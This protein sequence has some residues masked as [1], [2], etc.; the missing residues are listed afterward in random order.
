MIFEKTKLFWL[1]DVLY[2]EPQ[3]DIE[4][5]DEKRGFCGVKLRV[6]ESVNFIKHQFCECKTASKFISDELQMPN[7]CKM[8]CN[9]LSDCLGFSF[10]SD[11]LC[12]YY[13][14]ANTCET[15]KL[16]SNKDFECTLKSAQTQERGKLLNVVSQ[17]E[18]GCWIKDPLIFH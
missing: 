18:R 17:S 10:S 2:Q 6:Q 5:E 9:K 3:I 16:S 8:L 4:E 15:G 1:L 11:N 12:Q 13:T 14:T 7:F